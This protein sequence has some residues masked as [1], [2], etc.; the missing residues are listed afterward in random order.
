MVLY[1]VTALVSL[2]YL[3]DL[4]TPNEP[5]SIHLLGLRE[6]SKTYQHSQESKDLFKNK[7]EDVE[8]SSIY[9]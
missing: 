9:E 2:H 8:W 5:C 3:L 7:T 4:Q 6:K 1:I